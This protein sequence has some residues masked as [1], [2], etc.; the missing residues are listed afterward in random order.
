[1]AFCVACT[2]I[3]SY[4]YWDE[5]KLEDPPGVYEDLSVHANKELGIPPDDQFGYAPLKKELLESGVV[6]DL[7]NSLRSENRYVYHVSVVRNNQ[8]N[9]YDV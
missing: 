3:N 8:T 5:I 6:V 7:G 4:M 2:L 9:P 1:M